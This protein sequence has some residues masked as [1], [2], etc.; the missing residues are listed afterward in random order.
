M[1][2]TAIPDTPEA[3]KEWLT[4]NNGTNLKNNVKTPEDMA[5]FME[6]YRDVANRRDGSLRDQVRAQIEEFRKEFLDGYSNLADALDDAGHLR[7]ASRG[8]AR[9]N[10]SDAPGMESVRS[11]KHVRNYARRAPGKALERDKRFANFGDFMRNTW[12][13]ADSDEAREARQEHTRLTN[14]WSSNQPSAG[15]FLIP[16]RLRAELLRVG[17]ETAIMRRYARTVP[18]DSLT[19]PFPILDST[20]NVSS[21]FGG[22]AAY[23]TEE[24]GRLVASEARFGRVLLQARKLTAYA[25]V[26]N[27][28]FQDAIISL[29]MFIQEVFPDAMTWFEDL[30]FL[31]GDGVGQ[32]LGMLNANNPALVSVAAE[33]GQTSGTIVWENILEMYSRMLPSSQGRAI[34]LANIDTFRELATMSL[35]IGTGGSAIWINN[36]VS[37]PPATIL[38]R[39]VVFTEKVPT[40][41]TAGDISFVDP[42]YYLIGDRMAMTSDTSPHVEFPTDQTAMRFIQRLDGQP[43][44]QSPITPNQG[45]DTLSPFLSLAAR[46]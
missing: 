9:L 13:R 20:S 3:L 41:G 17:L 30:A 39:P 25:V 5:A 35:S 44:L 45:S 32:P 8:V 2:A 38:G 18:M 40:Q 11:A 27:E 24:A 22:I 21:V 1:T 15:G 10:L 46:P 43:W 23:W 6:R 4:E 7:E 12:F 28:L 19:V 26:P 36:G 29:E 37:G 33:P 16:E 42:N 31:R 34:W 14:A